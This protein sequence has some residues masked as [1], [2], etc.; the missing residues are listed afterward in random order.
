MNIVESIAIVIALAVSAA[1]Q[2][3]RDTSPDLQ[4]RIAELEVQ[5]IAIAAELARLK[6]LSNAS[7]RS[8]TETSSETKESPTAAATQT[9]QARKKDLGVDIG[10]ARLTPY[11]SIYF[12]AFNNSGGTN[13][14]DVPMWATPTG[15]S[16]AGASVRQTRLGLRLEGAKVGSANLNAVVEADFFGGFPPVSIGE[17]FGVVRIRLAN[18][19]LA[20][21]R[22]SVTVGQDWMVFAPVNP[23]SLAAAGIPQMAASGNPWARLPQVRI[24]QKLGSGFIW[25]G[26]VLAPQTGDSTASAAFLL[27][28][29]SGSTSRVPFFQGRIAFAD[30]NFLNTKKS[31]SVGLAGHYGK[32]R[33]YS[34]ATRDDVDSYGIAVDWNMPLHA[35]VQFA[36]EAFWG[37]N[38]GGFQSGI[39]QSINGEFSGN[40]TGITGIGTRGGWIQ[41]GFTPPVAKDRLSVYGSIGIDDP[42]DSELV[43]LV[44][45]DLRARNLT[46]AF[47]A[48]YKLTPQFSIGTEFRRMETR[49]T[50]SGR[51][52]ASH[53]NLAAVYSF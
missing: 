26:A 5:V 15:R 8:S 2:P 30:P 33:V 53:L 21:E 16:N 17:N 3:A 35:R 47:D 27:Q 45:R 43:T 20:W 49:W 44:P 11:G 24:E 36:G 12:N 19:K 18:A 4:K 39:F 50:I 52:N 23:T 6:E 37:S 29:N 51:R 34:G 46:F 38:L 1:A 40:T 7:A 10:T 9:E 31:G 22:T 28:P 14:T 42:D 48:I 32:S 13:N 25:Q 41:I